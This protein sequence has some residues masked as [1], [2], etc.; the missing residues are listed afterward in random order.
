VPEAAHYLRIPKA[1]LRAWVLGRDKF[2]A[3]IGAPGSSG[4]AA[5][6]FVNLVEIQVLGALR[7]QHVSLPKIGNA[8]ARTFQLRAWWTP[9]GNLAVARP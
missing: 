4:P 3:V 8:F 9:R 1:T 7:C 2:R 6:A 5:L